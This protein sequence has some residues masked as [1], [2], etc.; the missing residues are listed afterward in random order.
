M[1]CNFDELASTGKIVTKYHSID[2]LTEERKRAIGQLY[3]QYG[4]E[5]VLKTLSEEH[6]CFQSVDQL[7]QPWIQD[8]YEVDQN[9]TGGQNSRCDCLRWTHS[10]GVGNRYE[11]ISCKHKMW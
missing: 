2:F 11:Y 6:E 5:A 7:C 9:G 4:S 3:L 8:L 10:L 1:E